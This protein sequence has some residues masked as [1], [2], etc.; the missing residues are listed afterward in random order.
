LGWQPAIAIGGLGVAPAARVIAPREG[1]A[2]PDGL[3]Y[4]PYPIPAGPARAVQ[5]DAALGGDE[6]LVV[7]FPFLTWLPEPALRV[8]ADGQPV[9]PLARDTVSILYACRTCAAG[10][11]V[12]WRIEFESA[13]PEWIDVVSLKPTG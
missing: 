10:A 9:A 12:N 13:A 4:P 2:V 6:V 8:T 5:L 1:H 11:V 7:S 3:T